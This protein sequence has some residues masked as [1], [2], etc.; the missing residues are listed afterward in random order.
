MR[1]DAILRHDSRLHAP[2][3]MSLPLLAL[4]LP[5]VLAADEAVG[6][7][8]TAEISFLALPPFLACPQVVASCEWGEF[9]QVGFAEGAEATIGVGGVGMAKARRGGVAGAGAGRRGKWGGM[10]PQSG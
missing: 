9:R 7:E 3:D 6:N 4:H 10:A 8:L 1:T 5:Q 2:L